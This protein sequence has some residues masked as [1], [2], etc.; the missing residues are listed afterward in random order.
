M[1][2][3]PPAVPFYFAVGNSFGHTDFWDGPIDE[4]FF[5][6]GQLSP[7]DVRNLYTAAV[8]EPASVVLV[9]LAV[10]GAIMIRRRAV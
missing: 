10:G 2:F 6:Y 4:A 5:G 9:L 8:P 3:L 7:T 1:S